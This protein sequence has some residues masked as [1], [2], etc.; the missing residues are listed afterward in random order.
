MRGEIYKK[1]RPTC[2]CI[3]STAV[4]NYHFMS[5][6]EPSCS[7]SSNS[8]SNPI[9]YFLRNCM[10]WKTSVTWRST[11]RKDRAFALWTMPVDVC[12]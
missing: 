6:S 4:W 2:N 3:T 8:H 5:S 9:L 7:P 12:S 1:L 11:R 10:K